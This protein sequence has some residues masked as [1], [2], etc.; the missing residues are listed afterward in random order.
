MRNESGNALLG[1]L[2]AATVIAVVSYS[3][4]E[5]LRIGRS[6]AVNQ[7][8]L[9]EAEFIARDLL[10]VT[11]Y[12]FLYERVFY[13][14]DLGP[15]NM[16]GARG[17][18]LLKLMSQGIGAVSGG[19]VDLMKACGGFDAKGNNIGE[20]KLGGA[21][22]ICPLYLR[23]SLLS[24]DLLEQMILQPM[25]TK[26]IL[27][28]PKPGQYALEL[29]YFDVAAGR[30]QLTKA[31]PNYLGFDA[32]QPLLVAAAQKLKKASVTVTF[33]GPSSNLATN[34]AERMIDFAV[35]VEL[36]DVGDTIATLRQSI[37]I[38]PSTPKD[39]AVFSI[40]P[41]KANGT[42]RTSKWSEGLLLP[43]GTVVD[44]RVFF[45][46]DIDVP[47]DDLPVFN[48]I[49]VASGDFS[50]P[51]TKAQRD[52]LPEKFLK[53]LI[54]NFSSA[55]FLL[56][57]FCS[58]DLPTQEIVNGARFPCKDSAGADFTVER[59]FDQISRGVDCMYEPVSL[60]GGVWDTD[61]SDSKNGA[62][63]ELNCKDHQILAGARS[64][65]TGTAPVGFVA[66]PVGK[67]VLD[68]ANLYGS[69]FGG[70]INVKKAVHLRS[71]AAAKVGQPGLGS[72]ETLDSYTLLFKQANTGISVPLD[73]L[74]IVMEGSVS[75]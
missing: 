2:A 35:R 75:K 29:V 69:L 40:F 66:A 50:P 37:K 10:E 39:F 73:N 28:I 61:C 25:V 63:C 45:N 8:R 49:V 23:S 22:V 15:F 4:L 54:T 17:T 21:P 3:S 31:H 44:G 51:L 70:H 52:R 57:G 24:A 55:R 26:G 48:E 7:E 27:T 13:I 59:Y 46:G 5:T 38:Y 34:T 11:K 71:M 19:T 12:L 74:P 20:F 58:R 42:D 33:Y 56:S 30:D 6:H 47:F 32:G 14:D 72:Q 64:S 62:T 36:Q 67:A 18:N 60:S 16:D 53:G 9:V 43:K 1:L 65:V 68:V 41:T